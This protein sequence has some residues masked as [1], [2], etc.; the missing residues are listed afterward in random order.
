MKV[1][2]IFRPKTILAGMLV[3]GM[4]GGRGYCEAA[5]KES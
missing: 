1:I 2:I 4:S 5:V 3:T